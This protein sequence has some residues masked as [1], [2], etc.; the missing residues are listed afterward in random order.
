[1]PTI[2]RIAMKSETDIHVPLR[3]ICNNSGDLLTFPPVPLSGQ[4]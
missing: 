2:G 3:I 1:M 4:F